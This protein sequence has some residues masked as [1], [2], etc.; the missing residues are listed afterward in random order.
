MTK[1]CSEFPRERDR[2]KNPRLTA[3]FSGGLQRRLL[4][5]FL[6]INCSNQIAIRR[7]AVELSRSFE[8]ILQKLK[9]L[10]FKNKIVFPGFLII[11]AFLR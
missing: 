10:F 5:S 8:N 6:G 4:G 11:I 2:R 1:A 7:A 3:G 9:A